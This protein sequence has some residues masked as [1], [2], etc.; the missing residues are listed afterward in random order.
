MQLH[1][2]TSQLI[3]ELIITQPDFIAKSIKQEMLDTAATAMEIMAKHSPSC[4]LN[5]LVDKHGGISGLH[6]E[7][8]HSLVMAD[9]SVFPERIPIIVNKESSD[10][11]PQAPPNVSS[12]LHK[13]TAVIEPHVSRHVV[14]KESTTDPVLTVH[15]ATSEAAFKEMPLSM[16][17]SCATTP[18]GQP[19]RSTTSYTPL[20]VVSLSLKAQSTPLPM[21]T[22]CATTPAEQQ[23]TLTSSHTPLPMVSL[24]SKAPS[25][26]L[27][28]ATSSTTAV[29]DNTVSTHPHSL[30]WSRVQNKLVGVVPSTQP[31]TPTIEQSTGSTTSGDKPATDLSLTRKYYEVLTLEQDDI[32]FISHIEVINSRCSVR[33]ERISDEQTSE[34][35][36][37]KSD[38][39]SQS[40]NSDST[41]PPAVKKKPSYRPKCK[42]SKARVRAKKI[43]TERNKSEQN[44]GEPLTHQAL[45]TPPSQIP[46]PGQETEPETTDT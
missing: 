35:C 16:V 37:C 9:Q 32:I 15:E 8:V 42:L 13:E 17:T 3:G 2:K 45:I 34:L 43:I 4:E 28:M 22:C 46:V 21:V 19:S 41:E 20:S 6:I 29:Q 12:A 39:L 26:P 36:E 18:T 30:K 27:P 5:Q 1:N 25:T 14:T 40:T 31:E 38:T 44:D 10:E 7:D 23:S 33:L 11:T 24:S